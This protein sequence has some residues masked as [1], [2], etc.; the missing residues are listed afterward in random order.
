MRMPVRIVYVIDEPAL[1]GFAFGTLRGHPVSGEVAFLV[2]RSADGSIVL[3]LRTFSG[4]G[5]GAWALVYP[6]VLLLRRGIRN[7]YFA[8]LAG[9]MTESADTG[10]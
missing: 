4:P 8:A 7:T 9:P 6:L 10:L 3:K 5:R 1:K 2:E